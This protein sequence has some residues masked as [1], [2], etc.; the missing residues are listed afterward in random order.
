MPLWQRVVAIVLTAGLVLWLYY[1]YLYFPK[2]SEIGRLKNTLR[3][4]ELEIEMIAPKDTV[5]KD[6]MDI[7]AIIRKEIEG[8]MKKIPTEQEVPFIIDE[9]I[10]SVGRGLSIDYKLIQPKNLIS[11]GKYK[12]LPLKVDFE[13]RYTDFNQ[14][15]RA[16][17][18]LPATVRVDR[19]TLD[20]TKAPPN[21][22]AK[23]DLSIFVLPGAPPEK[24]EERIGIS[25]H[26]LFD[27]FF[28]PTEIKD[29]EKEKFVLELQGI[30]M[31]QYHRA[32]INGKVLQVGESI[33]GYKLLAIKSSE[34]SLLKDGRKV[35]LKLGGISK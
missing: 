35:T 13:S 24:K 16:L 4:V 12:R 26:Y 21:L 18:R 28:K 29:E 14:Y 2:V 15:L 19:L 31:G 1:T 20:K 33:A 5:I 9:L 7:E 30:W 32:I 22:I 27:P 23:M 11:E 25:K 10:S 17:K 8:L 3:T 6:G 34:V